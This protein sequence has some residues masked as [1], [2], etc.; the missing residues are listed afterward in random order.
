MRIFSREGGGIQDKI[1]LKKRFRGT[2]DKSENII[3]EKQLT[4]GKSLDK[5]NENRPTRPRAIPRQRAALFNKNEICSPLPQPVSQ[6]NHESSRPFVSWNGDN[7]KSNISSCLESTSGVSVDQEMFMS[8]KEGMNFQKQSFSDKT[9]EGLPTNVQDVDSYLDVFINIESPNLDDEMFEKKDDENEDENREHENQDVNKLS[10]DVMFSGTSIVTND[11]LVSCD[12]QLQEK[13]SRDNLYTGKVSKTT[14]PL[15][16]QPIPYIERLLD[17]SQTQKQKSNSL[18]ERINHLRYHTV[19]SSLPDLNAMQNSR[20]GL[21]KRLSTQAEA[22]FANKPP[23]S[24]GSSEVFFTFSKHSS[25]SLS[26]LPDLEQIHMR[27]PNRQR[28]LQLVSNL[29]RIEKKM[30]SADDSTCTTNPW[31]QDQPS[32]T[33]IENE[34]TVE[35]NFDTFPDDSI[36]PRSNT[37]QP[38]RLKRLRKIKQ[39][40]RYNKRL[41]IR[42]GSFDTG[43]SSSADSLSIPK[44]IS[45]GSGSINVES[46]N[47]VAPTSSDAD[48]EKYVLRAIVRKYSLSDVLD[49]LLQL[50]GKAADNVKNAVIKYLTTPAVIDSVIKLLCGGF[51]SSEKHVYISGV[52]HHHRNFLLHV[53]INGPVAMRN[54]LLCHPRAKMT[55]FKSLSCDPYFEMNLFD[56]VLMAAGQATLLIALLN[57]NPSDVASLLAGR[58]GLLK[59]IVQNHVHIPE[60]GEFIVQLC[61]AN[62]LTTDKS[63]DPRYGAPNAH[64]IIA[65]VREGI[66]DLLVDLF[67]ESCNEIMHGFGDNS[68]SLGWLR[69]TMS[70]KCLFELSRRAITVPQFN[71]TNCSFGGRQTRNLNAALEDLNLF[72]STDRITGIFHAA[73]EALGEGMGLAVTGSAA[74]RNNPLVIVLQ[75]MTAALALIQN[76]AQS[77]QIV[78]RRTVGAVNTAAMETVLLD[79]GE[80]LARMLLPRLS[81]DITGRTRLEVV[82]TFRRLSNSGREKTN[83]RLCQLDVPALLLQT[84]ID[85]PGACVLR[86]AVFGC[87]TDSLESDQTETR[88]P[89]IQSRWLQALNVPNGWLLKIEDLVTILQKDGVDKLSMMDQQD[90]LTSAYLHVGFA[91]VEAV[92]RDPNGTVSKLLKENLVRDLADLQK[93]LNIPCGGPKPQGHAISVLADAESL[94]ARL[95][96]VNAV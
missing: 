34:D 79:K 6:Q 41:P 50:G 52:N 25:S 8:T 13:H 81:N 87:L 3:P 77:R 35:D 72:R 48:I 90:V 83:L 58:K 54:A 37:D 73:L 23:A 85:Y 60:V 43:S 19:S 39:I 66:P 11:A 89:T 49:V 74:E 96:D 40:I 67:T 1:S 84:V 82:N 65:L 32:S 86:N 75:G 61:A 12:I 69:Q 15:D 62:P 95:D 17:S 42:R 26:S 2:A 33:D 47:F 80:R 64:G 78:T 27:K 38:T 71:K 28:S 56:R 29:Q 21:M 31:F 36:E 10:K 46:N 14:P 16:V 57:D 93:E 51:R 5:E 7:E 76:A 44:S 92:E 88:A 24:Y 18:N 53:Y 20:A 94:A 55:L 68:S 4:D 45:A 59:K 30:K 9:M 63:D 70:A 91:L 22:D